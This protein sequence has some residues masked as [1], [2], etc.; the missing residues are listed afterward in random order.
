MKFSHL[1]KSLANIFFTK[2]CLYCFQ[3]GEYVC[4]SCQKVFLEKVSA[5]GQQVSLSVR[6]D[7]FQVQIAFY[8]NKAVAELV[9]QAKHAGY[10]EMAIFMGEL[11]ANF[12][13]DNN[14]DL[15]SDYREVIFIPI[16]LSRQK[17]THRGFNQVDFMIKGMINI[18]AKTNDILIETNHLI[19][20]VK[21]TKTQVGKN[22]QQREKALKN[23]FAINQ[24]EWEKIC[25]RFHSLQSSP[26]TLI[27]VD[28]IFTTGTTLIKSAN[29]IL[30]H[31]QL[32]NLSPPKLKGLVFASG[33]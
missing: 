31:F 3:P 13:S 9:S 20:R 1:T 11:L 22:K 6:N 16:P 26:P 15:I 19:T 7:R 5:L 30:S 24:P 27:F 4:Q 28:D 21:D 18:L 14:S 10:K 12:L 29:T 33:H 2:T 32:H 17:L 8:Y 23:A 25:S